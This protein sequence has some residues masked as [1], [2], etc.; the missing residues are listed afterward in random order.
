MSE[1][2]RTPHHQPPPGKNSDTTPM[3][4]LVTGI[5]PPVPSATHGAMTTLV[6]LRLDGPQRW[7][8]FDEIP[9]HPLSQTAPV[10]RYDIVSAIAKPDPADP[11]PESWRV[12]DA[13]L[14]V[15]H[16]ARRWPGR[17]AIL[18]RHAEWSMCDLEDS[19]AR[20]PDAQSLALI[21]VAELRYVRVNRTPVA[22]P[23]ERW[24]AATWRRTEPDLFRP[25]VHDLLRRPPFTVAY[26]YH[27][28]HPVCRSHV[29]DLRDW[30]VV[31]YQRARQKYCGL[32]L[33]RALAREFW[34]PLCQPGREVAF[35]VGSR[36]DA[37]ATF[38]ILDTVILRR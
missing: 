28:H 16:E 1:L 38:D 36:R 32:P 8:R 5:T 4:V 34:W 33:R 19:A 26:R 29:Q 35:L 18:H 9:A 13:T 31:A 11:R 12:H 10:R 17:A 7:I 21:R 3:Q 24:S 37:P 27:C 20:H 6:G 22:P 15:R 25:V 14:R 2:Y 23:A 30:D